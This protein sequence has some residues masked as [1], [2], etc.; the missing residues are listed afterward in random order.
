MFI[1]D[2]EDNSLILKKYQPK[3]FHNYI[4]NKSYIPLFQSF[5]NTDRLNLLLIGNS[6]CGKTT[7]IE[8]IIKEYYQRD[9]IPPENLLYINNLQDQGIQYYRN[10]VRTFCQT[11]GS[12]KHKKKFVILDNLDT[13]NEQSQQVFRNYIDKYSHNIYFIASCTYKQKVIDSLQSRLTLVKLNPITIL[14]LNSMFD[15]IKKE[16]GLKITDNSKIE[17]LNIC[18]YSIRKLLSYIEKFKLLNKK[19]DMKNVKM[20]CN[21]ISFHDFENYTSALLNKDIEKAKT[22]IYSLYERGYSVLD[23][24]DNY[25]TYIKYDSNLV[26][27]QKFKLIKLICKYISIFHTIHEHQI[28]LILFT[29]NAVDML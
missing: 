28:E 4:I 7:N 8:S 27:I 16:E 12:I 21:N 2:T 25:F 18:D 1:A 29:N 6:G 5:I 26:E 9:T 3:R 10:D 24:F 23:I 22:I 11:K 20:I 19:I 14:D 15:Y 13:I 17:L